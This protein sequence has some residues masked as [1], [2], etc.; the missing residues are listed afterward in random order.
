MNTNTV[1]WFK[2]RRAI[3][4]RSFFCT[5]FSFLTVSVVW[6]ADIFLW[7]EVFKEDRNVVVVGADNSGEIIFSSLTNKNHTNISSAKLLEQDVARWVL[8]C[9]AIS[10]NENIYQSNIAICIS[11][12]PEKDNAARLVIGAYYDTINL[13]SYRLQYTHYPRLE[14]IIQRGHREYEVHWNE[15]VSRVGQPDLAR[16]DFYKGVVFMD[17][18]LANISDDRTLLQMNPFRTRVKNFVYS[19]KFIKQT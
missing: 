17:G 2:E 4:R 5:V 18:G 11:K 10:E 15:L 3:V 6:I 19:K 9:R 8:A 14:K 13:D 7:S 1:L 12:M 16:V